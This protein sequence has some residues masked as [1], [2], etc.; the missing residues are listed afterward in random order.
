MGWRSRLR[1]DRGTSLT[2]VVVA[3]F[4]LAVAVIG[5]LGT[6]GTGIGLVGH[7]RQRSA[8]SS[9]ATE[10]LERMRNVPYDR[11]AL[12][13]QPV[14]NPIEGH[15]DHYV[16]HDNL[17]YVLP[18]GTSEL[19][20]VDTTD[21][22]TPAG[23]LKHIDDPF[24]LEPDGTEFAVYQYVTWVED[25][26]VGDRMPDIP[27]VQSYKRATVIAIWKFP[28]HFGP[29]HRVVQST[30]I[31]EGGIPAPAEATPTPSVAPE[32]SGTPSPPATDAPA[33]CGEIGILSGSGGYTN[34]TAIQ[35][36]LSRAESCNAVSAHLRNSPDDEWV[37]VIESLGGTP[38]TVT[39]TITSGDGPKTIYALFTQGNGAQSETS[40][41]LILDTTEPTV[42]QNLQKVTV[43]PACN[44]NTRTIKVA[45]SAST[46]PL[47]GNALVGYRLYKSIDSGPFSPVQITAGL[48]ATDVDSKGYGS[49]RFLVRAYDQAGNQSGESNV[50]SYSKNVC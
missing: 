22:D 44:G 13:E 42:P 35:V 43:T 31:S 8:G 3:A 17:R 24:T 4:V 23:A 36:R 40:A 48:E 45:W 34:S 20:V 49:L 41:E 2:E 38:M 12:Y 47:P 14:H 33:A 21:D 30:V 39:W 26:V 27:G 46:D 6:M 10:R 25:D 15:P 19:L 32:P 11:L 50:V 7:S 1:D 18:D 16:T 5:V 37:L 9:L 28:L 29:K